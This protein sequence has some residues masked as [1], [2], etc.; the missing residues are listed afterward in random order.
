[1]PARRR[2]ARVAFGFGKYT[3]SALPLTAIGIG[4]GIGIVLCQI[5]LAL[6]YC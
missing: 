5:Y 3:Q 1:M 2:S 6:R 4:I